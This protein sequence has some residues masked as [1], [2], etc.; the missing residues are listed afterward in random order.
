MGQGRGGS[1]SE[2]RDVEECRT[3]GAMRVLGEPCARC[4]AIRL[5]AIPGVPRWNMPV[6]TCPRVGCTL[7]AMHGGRCNGPWALHR[8][9]V[10][11]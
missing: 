3:C 6:P 4:G 9:A 8:A 2:M 11:R 1:V 5:P 7:E 10:S